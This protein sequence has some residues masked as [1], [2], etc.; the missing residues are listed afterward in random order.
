MDSELQ[1][2]AK[3]AFVNV[4]VLAVRPQA[5][6]DGICHW[7]ESVVKGEH[8]PL[9]SYASAM[10][11][12]YSCVQ[13][14]EAEIRNNALQIDV[15]STMP[16]PMNG[17]LEEG[18]S[19]YPWLHERGFVV[20]SPCLVGDNI[21]DWGNFSDAPGI[22]G[23]FNNFNNSKTTKNMLVEVP[24]NGTPYVVPSECFYNIDKSWRKG[25]SHRLNTTLFSDD[26]TE[27]NCMDHEG[28]GGGLECNQDFWWLND[29][30]NWSQP[31]TFEHFE[32]I[33]E[34]LAIGLTN[35]FRAIKTIKRTA[36]PVKLVGVTEETTFCVHFDW[37]WLLLP[38][39]MCL[40]T[41]IVLVAT[42]V[43]NHMDRRQSVWKTNILPLLLF[44]LER[45]KSYGE[46]LRYTSIGRFERYQKD[47]EGHA[48]RSSNECH[49]RRFR[50]FR[51]LRGPDA[52]KTQPQPRRTEQ[53]H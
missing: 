21:Y 20:K 34:D 43:Q 42:L 29:L 40:I 9:P 25:F 33:F 22:L 50:L 1:E 49:D 35:Y 41:L 27:V 13:E 36:N 17:E 6:R 39:V 23:N 51:N 47:L 24:V 11:M 16:I 19:G 2:I 12:L 5:C 46:S 8:A 4:T 53:R 30:W 18:S 45:I 32:K 31:V 38:A 37:P 26:G 3:L 52:S 10:C 28:R 14:F 15:V 48:S 7:G 44:G